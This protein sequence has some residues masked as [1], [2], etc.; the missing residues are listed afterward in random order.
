M[1]RILK[2]TRFGGSSYLV[3]QPTHN[4]PI[5]WRGLTNLDAVNLALELILRSGV[6]EVEIS[7]WRRR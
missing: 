3:R 7:N 4:R 6:A 1:R 2:T 5:R